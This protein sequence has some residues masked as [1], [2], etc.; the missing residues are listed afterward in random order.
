MIS[1]GL[2][3][4]GVAVISFGFLDKAPDGKPFVVL[5]LSIR[6][7]ESIGCILFNVF[8]F[9]AVAT[10]FP[11]SIAS[12]FS[13]LQTGYGVGL[14]AGPTIGALLYD[15]GGF[16]LPF[17]ALGSFLLIGAAISFVVL[18]ATSN[19]LNKS[20]AKNN[21]KTHLQEQTNSTDSCQQNLYNDLDDQPQTSK[22]LADL[23]CLLDL[24]SIVVTF[25]FIGFNAAA[26]EPHLRQFKLSIVVVGFLFIIDGGVF[27]AA[28][29]I[30]GKLCDSGVHPK[31]LI[32]I[33]HLTSV[34][35]ISFIGP[36]A[37]LPIDS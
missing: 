29:P 13:I 26:L 21:T 1:L 36:L 11:D 5:A 23:S 30:V 15:F 34:I 9:T 32:L 22:L 16:T 31:L 24:G 20:K 8:N 3:V 37:I 4:V 14:L 7:I 19:K 33:G 10:L 28:S 12:S 2:L 35:G 6:L 17:L 18:P 27:A 25:A